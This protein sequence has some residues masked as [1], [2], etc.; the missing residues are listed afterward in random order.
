M[1]VLFAECA[2]QDINDIYD[3]LAVESTAAAQHVE[4]EIR[5]ACARLGMFPFASAITD[6]PQVRRL[7]V[8][9]YPY[10]IFCRIDEKREMVEIARV[11]HSAR[12]R[13]LGRMPRA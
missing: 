6:E 5:I 12:I 9:H 10:A 2:R 13:D 11:V 8:G 3:H 1:K 7:P 4:D